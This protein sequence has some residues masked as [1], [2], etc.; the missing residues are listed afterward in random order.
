MRR[1]RCANST[2]SSDGCWT[3]ASKSWSPDDTPIAA[4]PD[5][6]FPN[7]WVSF[8]ADGSVV[9]Y[10]MMAPSR[11]A[12]RREA[13]VAEVARAGFRIARRDRPE[14]AR[15]ARRLPRRHGRASC[16]TARTASLT[17]AT[18]RARRRPRS[19][20]SPRRSVP[21]GRL[22]GARPGRRPAY[23]TNVMMAIGEDFAIV[24]ADAIPDARRRRAVLDELE[25]TD[26]AI[27]E[28]DTEEMNRFAGNLLR[29]ARAAASR[30]SRARKRPGARSRPESA[31]SSSGTARSSQPRSR[32]SSASAAA[33]C[34]A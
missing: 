34:A 22:R 10:P 9:L 18:R 29:S 25:E 5:A 1:R 27:V 8:H 23:H 31:G 12:E 21:H 26:H 13:A 32:R 11:R 3:P 16:S 19:A 6:C 15:G 2:G 33:A 4:K 14:P 30:S 20:N 7:N 17:P 28:I 24:C